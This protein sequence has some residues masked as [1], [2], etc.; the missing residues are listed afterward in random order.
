MFREARED[1]G[2]SPFGRETRPH[3]VDME[4]RVCPNTHVQAE[5]LMVI[6][7]RVFE[8]MM[9]NYNPPCVTGDWSSDSFGGNMVWIFSSSVFM[10]VGPVTRHGDVCIGEPHGPALRI[11]SR[12]LFVLRDAYPCMSPLKTLVALPQQRY[13][14]AS[15]WP[16]SS[17]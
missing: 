7:G 14:R 1:L 11:S 12:L 5:R 17:A 8:D 2:H 3:G 13:T 10:T 6:S 4:A 16:Q 15:C 9:A